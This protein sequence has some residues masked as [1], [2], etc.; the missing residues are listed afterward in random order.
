MKILRTSIPDIIHLRPE[1]Y[2]DLRGRF[3]ETYRRERYEKAGVTANFVQDNLVH[4]NGN[5]FRGMHFQLPP[6]AQDK[7]ITLISGEILDVVLDL[8]NNADSYLQT[9]ILELSA[10]DNDQ[11]YIPAGFAHGYYV[12]SEYS[13]ISYKVSKPYAP[14]YQAGIRWND[15]TLGLE[16]YFRHPL[17]SP[18]DERLPLLK[19]V[20][21]EYAF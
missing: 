12:L 14:G 20:L 7:L 3:M 6:Y 13:C 21:S 1:A 10:D 2:P 5:V 15:E 11:L 8:R 18:K 19:D 4:S 17:L 16:K 9:L